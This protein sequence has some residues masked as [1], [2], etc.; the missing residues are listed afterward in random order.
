L[1]NK[2]I[3]GFI[4]RTIDGNEISM[5]KYRG[6][7]LLIANTAS[8]CR[9]T[10]QLKS[11]ETLHHQYQN[12]GFEVLAFPSNDF[13]NQEPLNGK[14]IRE[15]CEVNFHTTFTVFN[16]IHVKGKNADPLFNFLSEKK[17]LGISYSQPRWNFYKYLVNREGEFVNFFVTLTS[18]DSNRIHRSIERYL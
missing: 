12:S 18:P 3:Y 11:L 6:K 5:D 8:R 13:S 16:K 14:A 9:W 4:V 1:K 2:N 17:I 15:F 7:V 10:P